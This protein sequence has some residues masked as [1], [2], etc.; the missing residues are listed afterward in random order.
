MLK[1][2]QYC[3]CRE[4]ELKQDLYT[5]VHTKQVVHVIMLHQTNKQSIITVSILRGKR[6]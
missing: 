5:F 6:M 2:L 3:L 1:I 4:G